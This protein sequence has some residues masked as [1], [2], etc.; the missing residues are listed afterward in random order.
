MKPTRR[1]PL[2]A[3]LRSVSRRQDIWRVFSDFLEMSA[4]SVSNRF[5]LQRYTER[6]ARYLQIVKQYDKNELTR[7][8]Q[9]LGELALNLSEGYS[10]VLGRTFHDLELHNKYA[11]QFFTPYEISLM[12]AQITADGYAKE[13]VRE[14]G[15]ITAVEP[16]S[17]SGSTL[18]AFADA[19]RGQ[20]IDPTKQLHVTAVDID[21]KCVHMAYLQMS[22]LGIPGVIIHGNSLTL[23]ER[24]HWY[25]P[26]HIM[27]G[28]SQRLKNSER[29]KANAV[30]AVS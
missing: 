15:F 11:G 25:T 21:I 17:G 18:I 26:A 13:R 16:A 10:D 2:A 23:E 24:S 7:I 20:G 5:D 9:A 6:E 22:L 30:Q 27:G 19:L 3:L 12:M 29:V 8:A 1:M 28:W 4:V 14:R